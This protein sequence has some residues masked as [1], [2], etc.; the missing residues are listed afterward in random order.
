MLASSIR[1]VL[2][3][4]PISLIGPPEDRQA[5]FLSGQSLTPQPD[6]AASSDHVRSIIA[7]SNH[8]TSQIV[9]DAAQSIVL[10]SIYQD[11]SQS[12][13]CTEDNIV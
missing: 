5:V 10:V 6:Y 4:L 2:C 13:A 7:R 11:V 8:N 3:K 9:T 12:I 1:G